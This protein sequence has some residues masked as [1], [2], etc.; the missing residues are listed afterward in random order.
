MATACTQCPDKPDVLYTT[1]LTLKNYRDKVHSGVIK[2]QFCPLKDIRHSEIEYS[3]K[4]LLKQHLRRQHHATV[5][6]MKEYVPDGR[7]G[8]SNNKCKKRKPEGWHMGAGN[9]EED[10][11]EDEIE[12]R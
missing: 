12:G 7:K 8:H 9:V 4:K 11:Q 5:E 10:I 2:E 3:E 6:E 1:K